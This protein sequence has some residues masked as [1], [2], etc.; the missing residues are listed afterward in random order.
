MSPS[1]SSQPAL[2]RSAIDAPTAGE[3]LLPVH[4]SK[5]DVELRLF[6]TV[7]TF[8]TPHDVTL[9]VSGQTT[10]TPITSLAVSPFNPLAPAPRN[11]GLNS[12]YHYLFERDVYRPG[13]ELWCR[14]RGPELVCSHSPVAGETARAR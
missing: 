8:G 14:Q 2:P 9:P 13:R 6:S 3:L 5:D 1:D 12:N 4:I 7:M 10:G 11:N